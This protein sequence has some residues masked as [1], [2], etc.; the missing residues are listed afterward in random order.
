MTTIKEILYVLLD[1]YAE[2]EIGF[3]PEAVNTDEQG[4]RKERKYANKIVAP[5]LGPVKSIGG[6]RTL[7]DYSFES[8][9]EDYAALVLI[10]GYGWMTAEAD[11]V[12]PIVKQA[13]SK[14][15]IVGGI[16]N[17]VSWMAK[18]GLLNN[19]KHTGNGID[20]LKLWG[21]D[22][23]TNEGGY[24][25]EQIYAICWAATLNRKVVFKI[26]R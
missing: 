18:Q 25:N 19:I 17:A 8:M 4:F 23:Y 20:Q 3:L 26:M 15:I 1:N 21:G 6:M 7:P 12:V 14:G 24:L 16:C 10:G 11:G 5:T 13:L 22:N 9:P 2:Y